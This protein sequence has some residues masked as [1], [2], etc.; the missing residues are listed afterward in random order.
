MK[1]LIVIFLTFF[2]LS[3]NMAQVDPQIEKIKSIIIEVKNLYAP[4]KRTA[5]FDVQLE[6]IGK[7]FYIK[8]ETNLKEAKDYLIQKLDGEGLIYEDSVEVLPSTLL[9]DKI[10][11]IIN[12]SVANLRSNPENAAELSTQALLG[13]PIKVIKKGKGGFY[14]VQTPDKYISWLD[15]DGFQIMNESTWTDWKKSEKI[16]YT[17]EFGWA[18]ES[19]DNNSQHISDLVVGNLLKLLNEESEFYKVEFP[20][21][22]IA[23]V[24]KSES[25]KFI[26]WYNRLNPDG[27]SIL[28]TA[29]KFMG[30]PYLWG[31]TSSKGMDCSGFTKTVY[32]LN[33]I[34]LQRDA[35]QQVNTGKLV[36][37]IDSWES[38]QPG[39]LLFFGT[40]A[41][42]NKKER[43]THVAIYIGDGD[44]IH[45]AGRVRVN[46]FNKS[47]TYY[48]EDRKKSFIRAKRIL[49]SIGQNGIEQILDNQF[50]K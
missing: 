44:F 22:R 36:E 37:A 47:K 24:S 39:D 18:Y 46:S 48:S 16:I 11:G 38:F 21:G 4:D 45:A 19:P 7:K 5:L 14:L 17:K 27:E 3:K 29:F 49:N 6:K 23:F 13:T 42:G 50:Y 25:E 43:I 2:S 9:G 15:D 33:G 35:S 1:F 41:E 10:Y 32:F 12:L 28:K 40:K 8:G 30:V 20:D 26:D 34:V 31:G